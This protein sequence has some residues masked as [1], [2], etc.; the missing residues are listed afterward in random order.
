MKRPRLHSKE[1]SDAVEG[2]KPAERGW[3]VTTARKRDS[4]RGER[5]R[6]RREAL[7][8][9]I[10]SSGRR[11][12]STAFFFRVYFSAYFH[13]FNTVTRNLCPSFRTPSA[14]CSLP[15][16]RHVV[17]LR[18]LSHPVRRPT[19]RGLRNEGQRVR[20]CECRRETGGTRPAAIPRYTNLLAKLAKLA[21]GFWNSKMAGISA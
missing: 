12:L 21:R 10:A 2:T 14:L 20:D 9:F 19:Q 17:S 16:I 5:E 7:R 13:V 8:A 4:E 3:R 11:W 6:E 1:K 15:S 18:S